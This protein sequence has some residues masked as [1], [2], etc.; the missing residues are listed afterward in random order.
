MRGIPEV[1]PESEYA[2]HLGGGGVGSRK[3]RSRIRNL[4]S[5]LLV[6]STGGDFKGG[7]YRGLLFSGRADASRFSVRDQSTCLGPCL[8]GKWT[9]DCGGGG[10]GGGRLRL[11]RPPLLLLFLLDL[12]SRLSRQRLRSVADR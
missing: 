11:R 4:V 5:F 1:R 2:R 9:V 8:V 7:F 12:L 10:R 6:G 3:D